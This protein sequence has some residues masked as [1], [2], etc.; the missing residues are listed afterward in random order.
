MGVRVP[1]SPPKI[2]SNLF[3]IEGNPL[4]FVKCDIYEATHVQLQPAG[5]VYKIVAKW[6]VKDRHLNKPSEGG[7]GVRLS[8]GADIDMWNAH[9][10]FKETNA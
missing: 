10:Y 6:G 2:M 3:D 8:N 1:P 9:A 4:V 5:G 7:F